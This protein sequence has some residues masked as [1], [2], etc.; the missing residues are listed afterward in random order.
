MTTTNFKLPYKKKTLLDRFDGFLRSTKILMGLLIISNA[1][2]YPL[3]LVIG[4]FLGIYYPADFIIIEIIV[5]FCAGILV[6]LSTV[7]LRRLI[8]YY[9]IKKSNIEQSRR[10]KLATRAKIISFVL[11]LAI[12]FAIV[13]VWGLANEYLHVAYNALQ[14]QVQSSTLE[15]LFFEIAVYLFGANALV[16]T[17]VI[18]Y[19]AIRGF[20]KKD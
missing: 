3:M 9:K 20:L 4:D 14:A 2:F 8:R 16:A 7:L 19:D 6:Y 5:S 13:F 18:C 17:F 1:V 12:A 10:E 11:R 15:D